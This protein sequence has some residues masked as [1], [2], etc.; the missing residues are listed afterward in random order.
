MST[1]LPYALVRL[2]LK[3][4]LG[5]DVAGDT[6]TSFVTL[7]AF[8]GIAFVLLGAFYAGACHAAREPARR[9]DEP[10]RPGF[11]HTTRRPERG[12]VP[13]R[14]RETPAPPRSAGPFAHEP[15]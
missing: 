11:I 6:V 8:I 13:R 5:W 10:G 12:R 2:A 1:L 14:T 15:G 9:L 4:A 3:G 7:F